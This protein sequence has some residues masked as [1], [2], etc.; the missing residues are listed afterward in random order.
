MNLQNYQ[1][2]YISSVVSNLWAKTDV[3]CFLFLFFFYFQRCI[4]EILLQIFKFDVGQGFTDIGSLLSF[5]IF[6]FGPPL[7]LHSAY[8]QSVYRSNQ[9]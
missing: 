8:I 1:L 7:D 3:N 2:V 9:V 5:F 6:V 4:F